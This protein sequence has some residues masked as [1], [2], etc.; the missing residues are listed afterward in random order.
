MGRAI[1]KIANAGFG[2]AIAVL[3]VNA[4]M[5]HHNTRQLVD[6]QA[7]VNHTRRALGA[8][9]DVLVAM[10]DAETGQRGYLLSGDEA[11]LAPYRAANQRI[12]T[13]LRQLE[14]LMAD[15]PLQHGRVAALRA[16]IEPRLKLLDENIS[17]RQATGAGSWDRDVFRRGKETMDDIRRSVADMKA[18]ENELLR[19][20]V[21]SSESSF[22]KSLLTPFVATAVAMGVI[23]LAYVLLYR[24]SAARRRL[25]ASN[26][27]LLESTGEGFYGI[28]SEGN[29]T[30]LNRAGARMI[31]VEPEVALGQNMHAL[32]HHTHA[33]GTSYPADQCPIYRVLHSGQ[34]GRVDGEV[35]WRADGTPFPVE[36][37]SFP[38]VQ[39]GYVQGAVV[40][41][42]DVT[43]RKEVEAAREEQ[44]RLSALAADVGTA[45]VE[46]N[47]LP[48]MLRRCAEALVQ[49]LDAAF[50]RI[51]T[52][53]ESAQ[54]L[55]LKASSG[56]Y[57][58]LNGPHGRVPVG[59]FK[60]GLIAEERKP[61]LTNAVI[62]DPRVSDQEW[63]RRE[64][65]LAFAG[66]PLIVDGRLVG[67]MAMFAREVLSESTLVA[68]ASIANSVAV[69]IDR[70]RA[71]EELVQSKEA[72]EAANVAK[73]QFLA[74][75]SHE[76]RTP[77]NAVIM[78]SELLQEEAEDHGVAEFIPDLEKIRT[79]GKHLLALVN[80]VLDLS[81]IEAGRMDLCLETF[82]IPTMV[83]EVAGTV[84][85]LVQKKANH[86]DVRCPEGLGAMHGD[87]TKVRQVL[88][89]LV[90]NASKFTEKG[91][92]TL[93]AGREKDGG[94]DLVTF[95]VTDT[96]IGMTPEQ[97][98]KLFQPF[99]QADASTTRKYG[100]TGLGLT[101]SKRFCEIMGGEITVASTPAE[102]TTFTVRLPGR[103]TAA[104]AREVLAAAVAAATVLVIDDDPAV[105]D[106]MTRSLTAEG[107]RVV[108]A[109]DGEE[110]IRLAGELRPAVIFL[111]VL[112]PR[113]DGWAVLA[114]FKGNRRL[115]D[116]P[117][118]MLTIV[119]ETEMGYVLGAAEY[120]TKPIDRERLS[121]VL[122]KYQVGDRTAQVLVVEDDDA[123]RQVIRRTLAKQGWAV[124]EAESG[125]PALKWMAEHK[126][127]L[128]LLDL[129]MPGMDG[130][131]FLGELRKNE[132][133]Q[134]IPVVVLTSKDLTPEER[135]LLNGNV[136]K[137]L[138]KGAYGRE[139]LLR[140]LRRVVAHYTDKPP[141]DGGMP[142]ANGKTTEQPTGAVVEPAPAKG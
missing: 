11:N 32:F 57:T 55:E 83:S 37:T 63:A 44:I 74:S 34:G 85:P 4:W 17:H 62:G 101:I 61:H 77:L 109:S 59:K 108:T 129:M 103:M 90:S 70:K 41:F 6:D 60:I 97:I 88:F 98:A 78:Y 64:G 31:G 128:I 123:T 92:V 121:G 79:A 27:L 141:T 22:Y 124:A 130:F 46:S 40:S 135:R 24:D 111:D 72:A 100:G 38:I 125:G 54:V 56:M 18:E 19:Q 106:F 81:K 102:G 118:I 134:A 69:G 28:D 119:N 71:E 68:M 13:Q 105:R 48:E 76:L 10:T 43:Q 50:A 21:E 89:N 58:H 47:L 115:A 42:A 142:A 73:S 110:G 80:S 26:Q 33:D 8:L 94:R 12:E 99:T 52:L 86:L 9:D 138:Q 95:R 120:L 30:F 133:W 25:A 140:E 87:L 16:K 53:D 117:V 113:M 122:K 65:M 2:L 3:A 104:P 84:E 5:S 7:W 29:C 20:R 136:E 75:M 39:D 49:H 126:P 137:I 15:N 66:Y 114:A 93:E 45:V 112:M 96:G 36:Y 1:G 82:D 51:W 35:F 14:E 116:T 91:T 67:V 139:A 132:A 23:A 127:S 131:E 107:V